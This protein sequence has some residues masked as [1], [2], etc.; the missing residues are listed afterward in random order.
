[1]KAIISIA[2][3]THHVGKTTTAV[4]LATEL[5]LRGYQTL[6]IDADLQ[7]SA[8]SYLMNNGQIRW[9]LA[10]VPYPGLPF[11]Q[12]YRVFQWDIYALS[13]FN[14]LSFVPSSI[15]LAA[16]ES[17]NS[18]HLF[19]FKARLELIEC[20]YDFV[21]IDTPSSLSLIT[22]SC[23]YASTYVIAPVAHRQGE[24]GLKVLLEYMGDM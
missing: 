3:M 14:N 17:F 16:F 6:L 21:I 7:A 1:M 23:L 19:D 5:S 13:Q 20:F 24:E 18:S 22:Q 11:Y 4:N 10:N 8:T 15:R 2:N 9:T 12:R